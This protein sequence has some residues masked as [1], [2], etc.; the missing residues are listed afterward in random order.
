MWWDRNYML[1]TLQQ[2]V[3]KII[4]T[5]IGSKL[6][7]AIDSNLSILHSIFILYNGKLLPFYRDLSLAWLT[8]YRIY[9]A[10]IILVSPLFAYMII[11]FTV[12]TKEMLQ[13]TFKLCSVKNVFIAQC[14]NNLRY[15]AS[16][17]SIVFLSLKRK[18]KETFDKLCDILPGKAILLIATSSVFKYSIL[19]G[20]NERS[21]KSVVKNKLS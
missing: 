15:W 10:S 12:L 11:Q 21:R 8:F 13:K 19:E 9:T 20:T 5:W 18:K 6:G 4:F 14:H 1:F 17:I 2:N 16:L 3:Y 7:N